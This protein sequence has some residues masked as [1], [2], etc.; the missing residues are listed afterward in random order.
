MG[1]ALGV[2]KFLHQMQPTG[3]LLLL[4]ALAILFAA[5][6]TAVVGVWAVSGFHELSVS[7]QL[8]FF[9]HLTILPLTLAVAVL[10][11]QLVKMSLRTEVKIN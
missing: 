11:S 10:G 3:T 5:G 2:T 6:A 7:N 9:I 4:V 8:L 1:K